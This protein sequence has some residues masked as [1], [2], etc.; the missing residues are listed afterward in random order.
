MKKHLLQIIILLV[1]TSG[2]AQTPTTQ[3]CLGA[4]PVCQNIY[5]ESF[6]PSGSGN[7]LNEINPANSCTAGEIYSIWYVFTANSDGNLGFVITPNNLNDDY[8]WALFDL[9]N[10]DCS[11]IFSNPS[12]TVSCNAAGGAN[13]NGPT[14]ATGATTFDIQGA[15]C[16]N[17]NPSQFSGFSTFNN[18]IPMQ[19]GNTY[20]LM[21]SN[22]SQ[23]NNGYEID[24]SES[25][26]L[27]V[28][29][30]TP[31]TIS[32]IEPPANCFED[33]IIVRFSEYIQCNSI[34]V[35][36][37]RLEGPGEP[38]QLALPLSDCSDGSEQ[39]RN[40][41][42]L[43]TPPIT[44]GGDFNLFLETDGLTEV[45][46]LCDN[47]ATSMTIPFTVGDD[48]ELNLS[49]GPDTSLVCEGSAIILDATIDDGL[50][51]TW[52]TGSTEPQITVT[53]G[54]VYS[55]DFTT[56]CGFGSDDIEVYVLNEPPVV[57]LGDDRIICPGD[58]AAL[59]ASSP[60]STYIWSDGSNSPNILPNQSGNY[61]VSVSNVCGTTFDDIDLNFVPAIQLDFENTYTFCY[62]DT[63]HI[64]VDYNHP[65]IT[66]NWSDGNQSPIRNITEDGFYDLT[67]TSPCEQ[68]SSAT[69]VTFIKDDT[70]ELGADTI[71]CPNQMMTLDVFIP[72]STFSWNTGE[73][74][75]QIIVRQSGSYAVTVETVCTT[76]SDE[77]N[78]LIL[79]SL[80]VQLG[81][82]TFL[83]PT[84]PVTLNAGA[85]TLADY[86]WHDGTTD[87]LFRVRE[88]G[89]KSV[90]VSN[91]CEEGTF[92][93]TVNEC[94]VCEIQ[95]PNVFSPNDD[96]S[97]D[98]FNVFVAIT[99]NP[100]ALCPVE[101][102]KM[103]VFDRWGGLIY[104]T[105][106]AQK[107]WDGKANSTKL[108]PGVFTWVAEY[109]VVEN[110]QIRKGT[111]SGTVALIR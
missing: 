61:A 58:D 9:T 25:T 19:A 73:T 37:F 15:G 13:C 56:S 80:N 66:Y 31:P 69:M 92:E 21:V 18:L 88:P 108:A 45:L 33:Q 67:V 46:D 59:D 86:V 62:G 7:F 87:S 106:D 30:Q 97:N 75:A 47:A 60:F 3:D 104:V 36:N 68:V 63:L 50:T 110:N 34:D 64:D 23:S 10:A 39:G 101:T 6:V 11:D 48:L 12:L 1:A 70:I 52:S 51:Y 103:Q 54:G 78:I 40:F 91:I 95:A 2:Y 26:G 44:A 74:T 17:P 4:I 83:C 38:Y 89:L 107:G 22:W 111:E 102:F 35:D 105:E 85:G 72:G 98:E 76:Q 77:I 41:E 84:M 71:L 81:N 99:G 100:Q 65:D 20:A 49:V 29:D 32:S 93:V 79:D 24:F 28:F 53:Q 8:D 14:G 90:F 55:V 16:N 96:G 82:D 57:E 5:S 27:G 109:S 42:L 43:I 94:E